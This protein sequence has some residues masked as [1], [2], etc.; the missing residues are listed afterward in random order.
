MK[1]VR[2]LKLCALRV[3]GQSSYSTTVPGITRGNHYHTRKVERFAVISGKASIQLRKVDSEEVI[4]Y[5]LDGENQ[6]MLT[7][8]FGIHTI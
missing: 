2:L 7:C 5:I 4:E 3:A 1:E 6:L 8:Q